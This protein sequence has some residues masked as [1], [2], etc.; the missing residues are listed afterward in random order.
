M[1]KRSTEEYEDDEGF[2][3]DAPKSTST[4]SSKKQ[5]PSVT[6]AKSANSDAVPGG[7]QASSDGEFWEVRTILAIELPA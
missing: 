5:K 6:T 7:G 1:P 2:V 4:G 3:E